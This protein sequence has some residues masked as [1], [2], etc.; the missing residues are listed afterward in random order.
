M[1]LTDLRLPATR[2]AATALTTLAVH[3]EVADLPGVSAGAS[4]RLAVDQ[5]ATTDADT[6]AEVGDVA[7]ADRGT[8]QM[9][10][11][12]T[13][14]GVVA[15]AQR[16]VD[17]LLQHLGERFIDP[18]Q[19]GREPHQSVVGAHDA[20]HRDPDPEATGGSG[21]REQLLDGLQHRHR[22]GF[23]VV[24]ATLVPSFTTLQHYSAEPDEGTDDP[25]DVEGDRDDGDVLTGYDEVRG[26]AR[27]TALGRPALA[28]QAQRLEVRREVADRAAVEAELSRQRCPAGRPR[29]V[30]PGQDSTQVHLA[31]LV[32]TDP[33]TSCHPAP[34]SASTPRGLS[35]GR[36]PLLDGG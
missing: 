14:V 22:N 13:E 15:R 16:Q 12:G 28:D 11:E 10:G 19:V 34:L 4:Q 35:P 29:R 1:V 2:C 3:E 21:Q 23:R 30:D 31:Q 26:P 25:V 27:P 18:S 7:D 24:A 17:D 8:A 6:A 36:S 32:L 33:R 20:W 5:E 9:F